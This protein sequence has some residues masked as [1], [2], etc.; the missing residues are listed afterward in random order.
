MFAFTHFATLGLAVACVGQ[1]ALWQ[2]PPRPGA[3]QDA[4]PKLLANGREAGSG[5]D[6][7]CHVRKQ[8]K[9]KLGGAGTQKVTWI[10]CG[11]SEAVRGPTGQV[12][13]PKDRVT[14]SL[15]GGDKVVY[16]NKDDEESGGMQALQ[17]LHLDSGTQILVVW[18]MYGTGNMH[19]WMVV[20]VRHGRTREWSIPDLVP[21]F[22]QLLRDGETAG[23]EEGPGPQAASNGTSILE[24]KLVYKPDEPNCCPTGGIVRARLGGKDG[25]L[26]VEKVWRTTER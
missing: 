10:R 15:P 18:V 6:A 14:I 17:P 8:F 26:F 4:S 3:V 11:P 16:S 23:K 9:L 19:D 24:S 1:G 5:L 7:G 25:A 21:E 22:S 2:L 12:E 13:Y 20:D